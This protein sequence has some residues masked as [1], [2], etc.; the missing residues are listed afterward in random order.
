MKIP[1]RAYYKQR[2]AAKKVHFSGRGTK[3]L[4]T[5]CEAPPP[6][7][8]FMND[9]PSFVSVCGGVCDQL[10]EMVPTV[11]TQLSKKVAYTGTYTVRWA[12]K[13]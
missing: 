13:L 3:R 9:I 10:V 6:R 1:K 11:S 5:F 8:C 7:T 4:L 12:I 2:L